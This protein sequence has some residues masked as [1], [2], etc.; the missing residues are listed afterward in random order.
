MVDVTVE[1]LPPAPGPRAG[2]TITALGVGDSLVTVWRTADGVRE[3]LPG[4]RREPM[5]DAAFVTDYYVPV[6]RPVTYEVEVLSGPGGASRTT[7]A[8]ITVLSSSGWLMDPLIP[9]T[10]VPIVGERRSTADVTLRSEALT[11]MEYQGDVGLFKIMGSDRPMA[12]FG[13][14]MAETGMDVSVSTRSAEENRNLK[15]LLRSTTSLHFRPL[16]EWGDLELEG[17]MFLASATVRQL[18]ANIM[19]GGNL[20]WWDIPTDTVQG[21]EMK[22]LTATYSYGDVDILMATYQQ[23]QDLMAGRTYLDDLKNPIGG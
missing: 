14:R 18:P 16:P 13:Q 23:K 19:I 21:P 4:Y 3:S 22:V 7:S 10:A 20:T 11:S 2:I 8:P 6:N 5:N 9:Q 17:S 1:V 12:L 15:K